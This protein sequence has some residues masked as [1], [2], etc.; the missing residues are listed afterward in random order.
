MLVC[1]CGNSTLTV[2]EHTAFT[3]TGS[4]IFTKT[5]TA[6]KPKYDRPAEPDGP[7]KPIS[8]GRRIMWGR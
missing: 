7:N 1:G 4:S 3:S 5:T 6:T 8:V 2:G